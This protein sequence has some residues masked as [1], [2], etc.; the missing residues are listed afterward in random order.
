V[1]ADFFRDLQAVE[2]CIFTVKRDQTHNFHRFSEIS[3]AIFYN[4]K[5][6]KTHCLLFFAFCWKLALG[7]DLQASARRGTQF[8]RGPL[9]AG[10][11]TKT[12][13]EVRG[14]LVDRVRGELS[15]EVI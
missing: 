5:N 7:L 11:K 13:I 6:E 15:V 9:T 10:S 4:E 12:E 1:A 14:R 2:L 3:R 8:L